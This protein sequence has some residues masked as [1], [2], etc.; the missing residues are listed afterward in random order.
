MLIN[1]RYLVKA[2]VNV[3]AVLTSLNTAFM[4]ISRSRR[5]QATLLPLLI[6]L[7]TV[8]QFGVNFWVIFEYFGKEIF[9]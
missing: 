5:F 6:S 3:K 4:P 2:G 8:W 9:F 1:I 7:T